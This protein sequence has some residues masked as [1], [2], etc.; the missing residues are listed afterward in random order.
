MGTIVS[1]TCGYDP[2][3]DMNRALYQFHPIQ[4]RSIFIRT[5]WPTEKK[6][7]KVKLNKCRR[8]QEQQAF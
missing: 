6:W 8:Q 4:P 3:I 1:Y 2:L 7:K 5:F